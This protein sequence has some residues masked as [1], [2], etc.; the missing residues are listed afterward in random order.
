MQQQSL[1]ANGEYVN[2]S[3]ERGQFT[4]MWPAVYLI[5]ETDL[6]AYLR[7]GGQRTDFRADDANAAEA[8][9]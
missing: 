8:K 3:A 7:C 1:L 9:R 4:S 6:Y 5:A 2:F